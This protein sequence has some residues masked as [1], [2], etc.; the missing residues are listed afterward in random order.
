MEDEMGMQHI[1]EEEEFK[2]DFSWSNTVCETTLKVVG[3]YKHES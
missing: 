1:R 3:K 2:Q